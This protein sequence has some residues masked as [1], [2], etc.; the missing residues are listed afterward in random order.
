MMRASLP[1]MFVGGVAALGLMLIAGSLRVVRQWERVAQ[2]SLVGVN[3]QLGPRA[4]DPLVHAGRRWLFEGPRSPWLSDQDVERELRRVLSSQSVHAFR[5]SQI[6]HA[7]GAVLAAVLWC[8]LRALSGHPVNGFVLLFMM[9]SA[10]IAGGWFARWNLRRLAMLR[11]ATIE[12]ELPIVTDLLAFAVAAGEPIVSALRRI[13]DTC[14]GEFVRELSRLSL[15]LSTGLSLPQALDDIDRALRIPAV[16]RMV[17]AISVALE[18]GTPMAEVLRAQ[19]SDSRAEAARA[20]LV[21]A[22]KKETAMMIPVVFLILPLIVA[23]ALYPG[24]I[25]LNILHG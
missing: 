9:A 11:M 1:G 17:R 19:A 2:L 20:L 12:Q 4:S 7:G 21:V 13:C 24:L 10:F 23:V 16:S 22:G 15:S 6:V 3:R 18:R 8:G 25:A 5:Q 14:T